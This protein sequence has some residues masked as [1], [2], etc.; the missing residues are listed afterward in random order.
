MRLRVSNLRVTYHGVSLALDGVSLEVNPG[1]VVAILGPNGAGKTT[2]VRAVAGLLPLYDG[3]VVGGSIRFGDPAQPP[4]S[5]DA[6]EPRPAAEVRARGASRP[7][8]RGVPPGVISLLEGRPVFRYLSVVEN[9][10]VSAYRVPHREFQA[11]LERVYHYFPRLRDRRHE[12]AGY[13]SGGEQQMLLLAMALAAGPQLLVVDEPSLGLAPLVVQELF[14][15]LRRLNQDEGISMLLV[16]QNAQMALSVA[17]HAYVL[18]NGRVV[19]EGSAQEVRENE[20]VAEFYLGIGGRAENFR[21]ARRYRRRK[22][23][24]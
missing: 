1:Q 24:L 8:G 11:R 23:W 9:L 14:D 19:L 18:E 22:R 12:Q 21:D 2:L 20:D 3:H 4:G 17:H 6:T 5:A 15:I 7:S 10:R 16:E 13:L